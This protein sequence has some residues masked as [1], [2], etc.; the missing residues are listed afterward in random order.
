MKKI[1]TM[2]MMA[3]MALAFTSCEDEAIAYDLEGT[4]RG[5]MYISSRYNDRVYN[6]TYTEVTFDKNPYE[7]ASGTGTWVD[8]YDGNPGWG[9]NYVANHITWEVSNRIIRIWFRNEGTYFEIRDYSLNHYRFE[10]TIWDNG[11]YVDFYLTKVGRPASYSSYVWDEYY[12][13]DPYWART[14][15]AADSTE[16]DTTATKNIPMRFVNPK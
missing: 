10:G 14:R 8:Y 11:N 13:N 12:F 5:E 2:L 15:S 7:Y 9:T 3:M 6:T 16:V 4:W 1:Y